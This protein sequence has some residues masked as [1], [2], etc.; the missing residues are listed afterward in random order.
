MRPSRRCQS[1]T[2]PR[3][4]M[5]VGISRWLVMR[6]LTITS[7][8]AKA[9]V[10]VA[11]FLVKREGDVVGPLGMDGMGAGLPALFRIGDRMVRSRSRLRSVRRRVARDVTVGGDDDG[12]GVADEID[13]IAAPGCDDAGHADRAARRHRA[14]RRRPWCPRR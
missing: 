10:D 2:T 13:A 12:H 8:S 4:S 9:L 1:A 14:R 6:C 7:A 11:A 3:V 5:A